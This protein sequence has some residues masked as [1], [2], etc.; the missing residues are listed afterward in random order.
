MVRRC[1][2][3]GCF[4]Y[5]DI[6]YQICGEC[7][8]FWEA[9][10]IKEKYYGLQTEEEVSNNYVNS[11]NYL[12]SYNKYENNIGKNMLLHIKENNNKFIFEFFSQKL[13]KKIVE[14][15]SDM[16]YNTI[17]INVPRSPLSIIKFGHDQSRELA[18]RISDILR[19]KYVNA[20]KY[21]NKI[22]KTEQKTLNREQRKKA[23]ENKYTID[24]ETIKNVIG[25]RCILLDD[26]STTGETLSSCARVLS[27]NGALYVDCVT[28]AK[29]VM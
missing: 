18:Q 3:C 19:I 17:I 5:E 11:Y 16:S 21:K 29:N 22:N 23:S 9:L 24:K 6:Q 14:K 27:E 10:V 7:L 13:S 28:V 1:I 25:A 26:I 2:G 20:L 4:L 12:I 15:F 8:G